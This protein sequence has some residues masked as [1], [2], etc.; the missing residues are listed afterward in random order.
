M[1]LRRLMLSVALGLAVAALAAPIASADPAERALHLRSQALNERYA[2][3]AVG[4]VEA[5]GTS[6]ASSPT[7]SGIDLSD[8][9]IA[10]LALSIVSLG[11][12]A[13]VRRRRADPVRGAGS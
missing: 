13:A 10:V 1:S 11:G 7:S 4:G 3:G 6:A 8:A 12:Y 9:G 5:P 2:T